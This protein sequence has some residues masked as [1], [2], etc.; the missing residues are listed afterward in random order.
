[1]T[2]SRGVQ[3]ATPQSRLTVFRLALAVAALHLAALAIRPDPALL[4]LAAFEG[5]VGVSLVAVEFWTTRSPA[6][7]LGLALTLGALVGGLLLALS[8]GGALWVVALVFG[9]VAALLLYGG[10]R[11]Q[12]VALGRVEGSDER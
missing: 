4:E 5:I 3:S 9:A 12:L 8:L 11:Y 2:V 1:M 10:H 6:R 7:A